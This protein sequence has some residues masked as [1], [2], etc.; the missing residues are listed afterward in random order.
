[1][2]DPCEERISGRSMK[3]LIDRQ[4]KRKQLKFSRVELASM[5]W[6]AAYYVR[7]QRPLDEHTNE[8]LA[9]LDREFRM[10]WRR[11]DVPYHD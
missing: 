5:I 2:V 10:M 8:L 11:A 7:R 1:M 9:Y 3:P 4:P 6:R